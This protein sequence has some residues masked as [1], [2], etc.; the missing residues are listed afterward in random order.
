MAVPDHDPANERTTPDPPTIRAPVDIMPTSDSNSSNVHSGLYD[1]GDTTL[2]MRYLRDGP[3]AIY[4]YWGVPASTWNG[5][6]EASSK[7]S[8]VNANIGYVY[9]YEKLTT[10]NFPDEGQ[11]VRNDL[12]RRF[13]TTP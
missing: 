6:V 1:F 12:V 4:Q 2:F 7:G 10:S 3:D 11:G 13:L 9:A 5:L 8:Y